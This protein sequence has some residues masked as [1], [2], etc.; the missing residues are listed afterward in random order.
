METKGDDEYPPI[1]E[2]VSATPPTVGW[3]TDAN[4]EYP[5]IDEVSVETPPTVDWHTDANV[6]CPEIDEVPVETLPTVATNQAELVDLS[7]VTEQD[8]IAPLPRVSETLAM[9]PLN[10]NEYQVFCDENLDFSQVTEKDLER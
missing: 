1:A 6:E 4:E 7:N 5:E 9:P 2:V 8:L 10:D 3:H